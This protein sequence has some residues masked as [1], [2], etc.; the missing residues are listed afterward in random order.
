MR[1]LAFKSIIENEEWR[2]RIPK[3]IK[4]SFGFPMERKFFFSRTHID[5]G[6]G[7]KI[8]HVDVIRNKVLKYESL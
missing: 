4:H 3:I 2:I 7:K 5:R 8:F 6:F 1:T